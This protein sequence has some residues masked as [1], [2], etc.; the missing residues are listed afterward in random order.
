MHFCVKCDN[1]YYI[2]INADDTNKLLYYCRHCGHKDESIAEDGLCVLN[3]QLKKGEQKFNHIINEYTKLDPTL[4]RIYS[5]KCP[6]S[7]CKTHN[8]TEKDKPTEI[9]YMRYDDANMKYL[10]ICAECDT[11]WKTDDPR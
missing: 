11:T 1:M 7:E 2:G 10:Y 8:E 3:T 6:N 9:I 4:P 5:M